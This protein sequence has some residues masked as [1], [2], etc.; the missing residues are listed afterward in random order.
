MEQRAKYT[1]KNPTLLEEEE[2][3]V[4]MCAGIGKDTQKTQQHKK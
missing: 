1:T 2:G 4:L 3:N